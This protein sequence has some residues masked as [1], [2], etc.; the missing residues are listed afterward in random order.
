LVFAITGP[1]QDH[2]WTGVFGWIYVI[3]LFAIPGWIV[4]LP[5]IL[6]R[7]N[8][9][10]HRIYVLATIGILIGPAIIGTLNLCSWCIDRS[11]G[12]DFGWRVVLLATV[13]SALTTGIYLTLL[14]RS[15]RIQQTTT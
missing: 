13:I 1:P 11:A 3:S 15:V 5:F 14:K 12:T 8:I 7:P 10:G 6:F 9:E 4:A 2:W